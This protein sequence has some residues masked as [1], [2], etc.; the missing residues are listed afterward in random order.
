[1]YSDGESAQS[2]SNQNQND[3]CTDD[4]NLEALVNLGFDKYIGYT[5]SQ[6]EQ[7]RVDNASRQNKAKTKDIGQVPEFNLLLCWKLLG[8]SLFP[9]KARAAHSILFVPAS[10]S[11]SSKSGC[12]FS[13]ACNTFTKQRNRLEPS[14]VN[15]LFFLRSNIDRNAPS[16]Q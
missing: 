9:V 1:M 15:D 16:V 13:D 14:F 2:N 11:S 5:V 3:S 4:F 12:N 8:W 10:S 7:E 6:N